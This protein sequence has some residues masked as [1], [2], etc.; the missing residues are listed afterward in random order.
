[1]NKKII[2]I[3]VILVLII[4]GFLGYYFTRK[5]N[6]VFCWPDCP[7]MTDKDREAIK[8]SALDAQTV[9]W[10]T[11][12]NTEY[13]YTIKYP[14]N[15]NLNSPYLG[16]ITIRNNNQSIT[17]G[18][19]TSLGVEDIKIS[20]NVYTNLLEKETLESWVNR[21]GLSDKKN[22]LVD[23]VKAIRGRMIYTGKE[24][25]GYYIKGESSGSDVR[26]IHNNKGY[27]VSYDPYNSKLANTFDQILSTFKF[28]AST[29]QTANWKTYTDP[30]VHKSFKYP[31]DWTYQKI[32]CNLDGVAFCPLVGNS[33]LNC[34]VTCS[35]D[36]L[37]SPI[38]FHPWGGD[39]MLTFNQNS[40]P[41]YRSIYNE[42]L[43]TLKTIKVA[44]MQKY[45]D[46]DFGFSFWYPGSWDIIHGS[47]NNYT[48]NTYT[49]GTIVRTITV[50]PGQSSDGI[51]IEE[52]V[53]SDKSVTDNSNC[54][55][56]E[57]CPSS[58]R[59]Y[60]DS[61][62]HTWMKDSYFNYGQYISPTITVPADVSVNSMGGLHILRGNARFDDNVII[63]LSAK[64]FLIV[65]NVTAGTNKIQ[66]LA[67]T[68]VATDLAVATPVSLEEQT[69]T[70]QAEESAY[71]VKSDIVGIST[72][73]IS[74][75]TPSLGSVGTFIEL[76]GIGFAGFES[77][78]YAWI[79]NINTGI[80]G[81]IYGD[82]SSTNNLIRFKLADKYCTVDNSYS[83]I[84]CSSYLTIT[85]GIYNIYVY[86]WGKKSNVVNFEVIK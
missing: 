79:E 68:I 31:S 22:I 29:N 55:P 25:S 64:N 54:G 32:S 28:I 5:P 8:Q 44:G 47:V 37:K 61:S 56:A 65:H 2:W 69:K 21:I 39:P 82:Q 86:P 42:M 57:G 17:E 7:G 43:A 78:K 40:D 38:Y 30:T 16:D 27:Q 84:P 83:G 50:V 85:P 81:V 1:M 80:E 67:K 52:F 41:S 6:V 77:D 63:P 60:F 15:F 51:A 11:Y 23:G 3:A 62:T 71:G 24:E 14:P 45:T 75:I 33:P 53:S 20:V 74:S 66:F 36:D 13:G 10:K 73:I 70:I 46:S 58:V 49:G 35:L 34:G 18:T 12:T 59:Y 9:N 26:F 19:D 48:E 72:P 4:G 76:K